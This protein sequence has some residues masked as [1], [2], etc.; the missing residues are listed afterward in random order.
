MASQARLRCS[1]AALDDRADA[2]P[3]NEGEVKG[4]RPP[5]V[6]HRDAL[7]LLD[8]DAP[9]VLEPLC[10]ENVDVVALG[11]RDDRVNVPPGWLRGA[12]EVGSAGAVKGLGAV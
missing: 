8:L 1:D 3:P 12:C 4:V 9:S 6:P 2:G 7:A 5:L 10:S 11:A